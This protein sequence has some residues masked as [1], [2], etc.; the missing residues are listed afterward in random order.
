MIYTYMKF[1]KL[2]KLICKT[3]NTGKTITD[4]TIPGHTMI[5]QTIADTI[6]TGKSFTG[7]TMPG[8]IITNRMITGKTI[9]I[10]L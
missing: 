2:S 7:K 3:N 1:R 10:E 4:K 8:H 5:I 6:I 9:T